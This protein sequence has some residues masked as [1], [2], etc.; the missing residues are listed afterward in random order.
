MPLIFS[1]AVG[2]AGAIVAF[3]CGVIGSLLLAPHPEMS[4]AEETPAY[5]FLFAGLAASL[6][7]FLAG[8]LLSLRFLK[9][10]NAEE[11]DENDPFAA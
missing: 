8:T 6:P 11:A 10:C 9:K 4:G 5:F 2:I 7:G 1:L 3:V